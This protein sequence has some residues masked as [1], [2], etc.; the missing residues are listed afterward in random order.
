MEKRL[1]ITEFQTKFVNGNFDHNDVDIQIEAGWFDWF[2]KDSSLVTRT[3]KLG[4]KVIQIAKSRKFN[5]DE[6]YVFFKNNC[7][8]SGGTYDS[9]SICDHETGDVLFWIGSPNS[10]NKN[11]EVFGKEND[12]N[13]P[14]V[15]GNWKAVKD[16]FLAA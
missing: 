16:Y 4:K 7:P 11:Y 1:T 3:K 8:M 15:E 2:C 10:R 5:N 12:F 14:L 6:T 9:F 13:E